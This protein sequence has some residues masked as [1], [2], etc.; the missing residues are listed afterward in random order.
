MPYKLVLIL[1]DRLAG[2]KEES[3]ITLGTDVSSNNK[4]E[5]NYTTS[6]QNGKPNISSI[7]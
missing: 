1:K 5:K 7:C 4:N 3:K 2:S 6:I